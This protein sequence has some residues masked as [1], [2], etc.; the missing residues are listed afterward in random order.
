MI[1]NGCDEILLAD[2][3]EQKAALWKIRRKVGEAVKSNSIYKEEDTVVPRAELPLLLKGV[4][5]IGNKRFDFYLPEMN[6]CIEF[7]GI[8]HFQICLNWKNENPFPILKRIIFFDFGKNKLCKSEDEG[9]S[10]EF[11]GREYKGLNKD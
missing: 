6:I 11:I 10:V 5:E 2:S 7:D 8:Q 1:E 9:N 4:K 3:A